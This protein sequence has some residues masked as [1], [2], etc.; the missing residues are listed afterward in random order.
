MA[1]DP[2]YEATCILKNNYLLVSVDKR[3]V[4]KI[5]AGHVYVQG[6]RRV[7]YN[8]HTGQMQTLGVQRITT[9]EAETQRSIS[10]ALLT[11]IEELIKAKKDLTK[12]IE[13]IDLEHKAVLEA[14]HKAEG[15]RVP[16][17]IDATVKE[18]T[19]P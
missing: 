17:I 16:A 14:W 1:F 3:Q 2:V 10:D 6:Y 18:G 9:K 19:G 13:F 11:L 5:G 15:E 4:R 12:R 7:R 8:P